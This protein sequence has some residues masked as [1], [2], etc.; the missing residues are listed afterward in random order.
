MF[1]WAPVYLAHQI[2]HP[3]SCDNLKLYVPFVQLDTIKDPVNSDKAMEKLFTQ[4]SVCS[5]GSALMVFLDLP[6]VW[7]GTKEESG[8]SKGIT[9]VRDNIK[10]VCFQ[11]C[12]TFIS[13]FSLAKRT[14]FFL[15]SKEHLENPVVYQ[16]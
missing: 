13:F 3:F 1:L 15:F 4:P 11:M 6:Y 12:A 10:G 2:M 7:T 9:D 8:I 5:L 16:C 14:L